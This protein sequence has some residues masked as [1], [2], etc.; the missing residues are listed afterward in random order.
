MQR[1]WVWLE[2][3]VSGRCQPRKSRKNKWGQTRKTEKGMLRDLGLSHKDS[4]PPDP[5]K[6][7]IGR[8]LKGIDAVFR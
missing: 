7:A 2:R 8:N 1:R 6:G 3:K 5:E 4:S